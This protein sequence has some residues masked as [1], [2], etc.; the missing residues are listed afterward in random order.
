MS[1]FVDKM[2]LELHDPAKLQ[3]LVAPPSDTAFNTIKT[4][5]A[6]VYDLPTARLTS[7]KSLQVV[8]AEFQYPIFV[9]ERRTGTL[10]KT[11]PAHER[12]DIS[13]E[14]LN[15][16]KPQWVD[17]VAHLRVSV[18][19]DADPGELAGIDAKSIDGFTTLAEFEAEFEY[20]DLPAFMAEHEIT[21]VDELKRLAKFVLAEVRMKPPGPFDPSDPANE[22]Q[23]DLR[24]AIL[25][26]EQVDVAA[27]LRE[28]KLTVALLE[29][30]V[31]FR[32][33]L[34]E[35]EIRTPLAPVVIFPD[36]ALPATVTPA[37]LKAFFAGEHVHVLLTQP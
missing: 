8:D 2:L 34:Q 36:D 6:A 22:R 15:G 32:P 30:G 27:V 16:A 21:T 24:L 19:L 13:F 4:L 37:Q 20:I 25:I 9:G 7:V 3:A 18:V 11:I 35:A 10:T 5:F 1:A 12:T 31:A 14:T 26:R 17:V 28:A 29:R 33:H 23:F